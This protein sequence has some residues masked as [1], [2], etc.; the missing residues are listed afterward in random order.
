MQQC[1]QTKANMCAR[2]QI[3]QSIEIESLTLQPLT[4]EAKRVKV[5]E[6]TIDP[7]NYSSTRASIQRDAL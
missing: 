6:E 1:R 4:C 3:S 2:T 7:G 5:G